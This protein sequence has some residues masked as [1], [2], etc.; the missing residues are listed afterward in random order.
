MMAFFYFYPDTR[1]GVV[2]YDGPEETI[3]F[4]NRIVHFVPLFKACS[5]LA[6]LE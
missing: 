6:I 5:V 4:K 2:L 1:R 3:S